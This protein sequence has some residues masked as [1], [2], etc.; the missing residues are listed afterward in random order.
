MKETI[1]S[2]QDIE[3][4][5]TVLSSFLHRTPVLTSNSLNKMAGAELFFKCENFQK[6]GAFKARGATFAVTKLP[7][8]KAKKGVATHSSGNHGQALAL[9]AQQ[10]GIKAYV[11]MPDNAPSVKIAAVKGYGAEVIFCKPSLEARETT[12]EKVLEKTDATFI[13]PYDNYHVITG[14]A[15]CAKELVEDVQ[16][17]EHVIAPVGGGGLLAGTLLSLHYFAKNIEGWAAEPMQV[18]DA[19]LSLKKGEIVPAPNNKTIADGLRTSLGHRNFPII[20]EHVHGIFTVTE[21][22]ICSA[23]RLI[24]ERMKIIIEPS[25]AV[26]LAAL[27]HHKTLFRNKRVGLILTGGNVDLEKLPF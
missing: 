27:L 18:N 15:T 4:A 24:W 12:L 13:H 10:R 11:V 25:C 3:R 1:P 6:A 9:A 14:Q 7:E 26:P 16:S 21:E 23:M 17:L 8:E 19:F 20:K 22:E 2:K 5:H